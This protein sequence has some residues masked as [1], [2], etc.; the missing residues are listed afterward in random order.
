VP[1]AAPP[2]G[3]LTVT[4]LVRRAGHAKVVPN[5]SPPRFKDVDLANIARFV[6]HPLLGVQLELQDPVPAGFPNPLPP[7]DLSEGPHLSYAIQW[8][9]FSTVAL[10]GWAVLLRRRSGHGRHH[11]SESFSQA[12]A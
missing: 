2:E 10:V 1:E 5:S 6:P 4:G 12:A 3:E 11:P 9:G 7:L 8:F